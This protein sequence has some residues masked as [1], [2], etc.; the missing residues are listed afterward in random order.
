VVFLENEYKHY[1]VRNGEVGTVTKTGTNALGVQLED[2]RQVELDLAR[3]SALDYGYALTTYKSQGQTY[4]K[5]LVEADTTV[6]QLQ[7]Q[8]NTYVQITRARDNVRIFT[9]DFAELRDVAGVLTVKTDT[10]DLDVT[11]EKARLMEQKIRELARQEASAKITAASA[12][13]RRT[14]QEFEA[15]ATAQPEPAPGPVHINTESLSKVADGD[16]SFE[17]AL[18]QKST[19]LEARLNERMDLDAGVKHRVAEYFGRP[20]AVKLLVWPSMSTDARIAAA[21][22]ITG[23]RNCDAACKGLRDDE[24]MTVS[25][26]AQRALDQGRARGTDRARDRSRGRE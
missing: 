18:L 5:V 6:P 22:V 1:D 14:A 3:Y 20:E 23:T 25:Y 12:A 19:S 11:L 24:M 26:L 4:N 8:R 10:N 21:E 7:D 17:K 2:G 13:G 9:D 15:E 16:A